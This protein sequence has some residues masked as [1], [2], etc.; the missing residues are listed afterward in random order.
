MDFMFLQTI[1]HIFLNY[2]N[3][4][5]LNVSECQGYLKNVEINLTVL[6]LTKPH[7]SSCQMHFRGW[8]LHCTAWG[9][10]TVGFR[11]AEGQQDK[12]SAQGSSKYRHG[13][14]EG[15]HNLSKGML[16]WCSRQEPQNYYV[17]SRAFYLWVQL[18]LPSFAK[19]QSKFQLLHH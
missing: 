4:F 8:L 14:R 16:E 5:Y 18:S 9:P 17:N 1:L 10:V 12:P 13:Q 2:T 15:Q 19:T 7:P 3:W 11:A 6:E